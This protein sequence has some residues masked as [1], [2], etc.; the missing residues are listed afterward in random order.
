MPPA[1]RE[2]ERPADVTALAQ[3]IERYTSLPPADPGATVTVQLTSQDIEQLKL[4]G[5]VE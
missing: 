5:Y 1:S 3:L 2:A 4:L